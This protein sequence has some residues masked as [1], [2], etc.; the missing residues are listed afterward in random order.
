MAKF[1]NW[2][3]RSIQG[4]TQSKIEKAKKVYARNFL[5]SKFSQIDLE[6]QGF[7]WAWFSGEE[8]K[9]IL[10]SNSSS[11]IV[12]IKP[13]L[14]CQI[15]THILGHWKIILRWPSVCSEQITDLD[16]MNSKIFY[17]KICDKYWLRLRKKVIDAMIWYIKNCWRRH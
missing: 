10:D 6:V 3:L 12:Y 7:N 16:S 17:R 2:F 1:D 8:G 9:Q 14:C 13:F 4:F 5:D 15:K 11:K